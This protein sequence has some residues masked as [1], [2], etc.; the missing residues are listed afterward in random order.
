MSKY[1]EENQ[2][3]F[4]GEQY[5]YVE[6]GNEKYSDLNKHIFLFVAILLPLSTFI[7]SGNVSLD[8]LN[9]F[10]KKLIGVAWVTLTLSLLFCALTFI[11]DG[12][13]WEK[14]ARAM[15]R[16]IKGVRFSDFDEL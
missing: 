7:F 6:R 13:F 16:V 8:N 10:D 14:N 5:K 1:Q 3:K 2:K 9:L 15:G 12:K 11:V 4:E